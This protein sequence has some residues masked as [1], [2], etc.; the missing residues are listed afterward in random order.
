MCDMIGTHIMSTSTAHIPELMSRVRLL[1]F[2]RSLAAPPAAS[3]EPE[4]LMW[5]PPA[6]HNRYRNPDHSD[7]DTDGCDNDTG[8]FSG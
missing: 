2:D 6:D 3:D 7:S 4:H 8:L 5:L 1:R